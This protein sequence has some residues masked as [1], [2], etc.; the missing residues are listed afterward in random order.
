MQAGLGETVEQVLERVSRQFEQAELFYGHGTDNPWDEA[1]YLVFSALGIPFDC[2][3]SML[4]KT[5]TQEEQAH[6]DA[7]VRARIDA[8]IPVAYLVR[9]AWFAG[10]PFTVDE[11]VL[12]PRSPLA[13]LILKDFEPLLARPPASVLDLCTGSGCIGIAT[14]LAFPE[15]RVELADISADALALARENVIRHGVQERVSVH[16]SDLFAS[17]AGRYDLILSNPPYVSQEEIDELP[18]EYR[19]EP[20]LGLHS[21]D[22]GLAIPLQILREAANYLSEDGL[23]IMEVGYSHEALAERLPGVP[24]L[25]L[26]FEHGGEG[27]FALTAGQLRE[28]SPLLG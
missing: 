4:Q 14:A 26:E 22:N 12:I 17:L 13:E 8:R 20:A 15:A 23:L 27:L 19:H 24:F 28:A 10:L 6:V 3:D 9:E 18:Q 11:R 25:W 2:D 5:L 7:L 16:Q 1:V 21:Q